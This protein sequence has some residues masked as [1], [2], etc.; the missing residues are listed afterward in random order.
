MSLMGYTE[1]D[2]I[3]MMASINIANQIIDG[4]ADVEA[5]LESAYEF[6]EGLVIEG[7]V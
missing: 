3:R 7:R 2:V 4:P 1:T 6:L 5:G